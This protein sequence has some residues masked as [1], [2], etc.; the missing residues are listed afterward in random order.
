MRYPAPF[1]FDR[2]RDNLT[3]GQL[4]ERLLH[5]EGHMIGFGHNDPLPAETQMREGLHDLSGPGLGCQGSPSATYGVSQVNPAVLNIA[6]QGTR[7]T[8]S[9]LSLDATAV[10]AVLTDPS[11]TSTTTPATLTGTTGSQTW[12][13]TFAPAQLRPLQGRIVVSGRYIHSGG[14]VLTGTTKSVVR[15]LLAP[16][17]P[18]ASLKGREYVG[19]QVVTINA[20]GA[21]DEVRY[22]LGN[23]AQPRPG[24]TVGNRYNGRPLVVTASQTLKMVAVDKAGNTSPLVTEKYT[25]KHRV[26]PGRPQLTGSKAGPRRATV[27]WSAPR[28]DGPSVAAYRVRAYRGSSLVKTA[29][30][31]G[32]V[33]RLTLRGLANGRKYRFTVQARNAVGWG[34]QSARS[35]PVV[36][37]GAPTRP[38]I[39]QASSG[40]AGGR[41]SAVAR[42]G[43]P[44]N[45]NG[46]GI[47]RY[48]V[49]ALK[50]RPSGSIAPHQAVRTAPA[51]ARSLQMTLN[52]GRYRFRVRAINTIGVSK[53]SARSNVV[54]A[55]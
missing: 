47:A 30:T 2:N 41:V 7:L 31:G 3:E 51:R 48:Q 24:A 38:R 8:V 12:T 4:R 27:R 23:G 37:R 13:A 34:P 19:R 28:N 33:N 39:G 49:T 1:D 14:G 50:L 17:P 44:A 22:T 29:R 55:R 11:G 15:D 52:R 32:R 6:N 25:I 16:R 9:G 53:P 26:V 5:G 20:P 54:R 43:R 42:W 36:P 35:R 10:T 46:S 21:E 45:I 40:S 18:T